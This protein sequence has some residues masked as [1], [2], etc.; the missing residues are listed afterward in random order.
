M[1]LFV[2][3]PLDLLT[4][5]GFI[6]VL[7]LAVNNTILLVSR[8]REAEAEGLS[9]EA[10]VRSSLETRLRPIFSTTL[11]AVAGMLPLLVIPGPGAE[12]YR[13]LAA[14]VIGGVL[15]S[16]VFTIVLMPALLRIG[17]R[18]STTPR[19]AR[20]AAKA[21]ASAGAQVTT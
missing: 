4:M 15:V 17:E 18:R 16:Q 3:Q 8:T 21:D 13:G 19:P 9:R 6:I 1:G 11:T 12:I 14:V 10:A 20:P 7:G 5:I 2:F